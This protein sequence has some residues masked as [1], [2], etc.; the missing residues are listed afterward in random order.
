MTGPS[1][2]GNMRVMEELLAEQADLISR[3]MS[4]RDAAKREGPNDLVKAKG[5]LQ[6]YFVSQGLPS[7]PDR[8]ADP[9]LNQLWE[10][11]EPWTITE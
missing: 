4:E 7:Y 10:T 2:L 1:T 9:I 11:L 6:D 8:V 3:L 5:L